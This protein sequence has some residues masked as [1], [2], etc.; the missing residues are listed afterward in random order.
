MHIQYL[1]KV[2]AALFISL[3]LATA[4]CT[5]AKHPTRS[6]NAP[7]EVTDIT[8]AANASTD[9]TPGA[10]TIADPPT[11][12][13]T[14]ASETSKIRYFSDGNGLAIRGTDPVAY[15]TQGRPITGTSAFTYTWGNATWQFASAEN[16]DLFA[17]NPKQYAPQ[18]GGFCA[19]AVSRGYTASIDPKAWKIVDGKLYLNYSSSVQQ[20]WERD[21][22]VN[23]SKA[24]ANWPGV[25]ADS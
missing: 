9:V 17:A 19:W 15:F 1:S 5:T 2:A 11:A 20:Q 12:V 23:I 3:T 25:L 21:I 18:Y 13:E 4:G 14:I 10:S 22:P 16:R 24:D 8:V 6:D 7:K